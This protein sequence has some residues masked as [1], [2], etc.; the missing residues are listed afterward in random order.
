MGMEASVGA[1]A[2]S[3]AVRVEAMSYSSLTSGEGDVTRS[4][5]EASL[6][7]ESEM[8]ARPDSSL[9]RAIRV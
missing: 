1:E 2:A 9:D 3:A 8:P 7:S 5:S 6:V 4:Q